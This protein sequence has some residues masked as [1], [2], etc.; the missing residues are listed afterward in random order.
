MDELMAPRLRR[1]RLM[2]HHPP[3]R[4]VRAVCLVSLLIALGAE[5]AR[6]LCIERAG[7]ARVTTV[8]VVDGKQ[9]ESL[10]G[11]CPCR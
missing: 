6:A 9:A 5:P 3:G 2:I 4:G 10:G 7:C 11:A 1:H 8:V